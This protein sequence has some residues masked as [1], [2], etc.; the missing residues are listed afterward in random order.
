MRRVRRLFSDLTT[1]AGNADDGLGQF[2]QCDVPIAEYVALAVAA[3]VGREQ[4]PACNALREHNPETAWD[5]RRKPLLDQR[6]EQIL[7][8]RSG[9]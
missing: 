5:E 1:A 8:E 7:V 2:A 3:L 4:L 6:L 9:R